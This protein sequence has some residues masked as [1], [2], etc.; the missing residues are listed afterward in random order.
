V[1]SESLA[2]GRDL[3][4]ARASREELAGRIARHLAVDG[5]VE[6]APGLY[7]YRESAPTG[8]RYGVSEPSFCVMAQG[9]KEVLLGKA[10]YRYDPVHYL[11]VSVGLPVV[12]HVVEA[13]PKRPYLAVRVV[14]DPA[15]VTEIL[16]EAGLLAARSPGAVR[17][18]AVSTLDASLLD[19]VLRLVRLVETPDD[20]A[21]LA[22]LAVREIVYRLALGEQSGRLRQIALVSG[23]AHRITEAIEF[24]RENFGKPLRIP[25]LARRLGMSVSGFHHHFKEVTAMSPLQFQKQLR[26]QEARRLL[27]AGD[28]DA[29][30]AG[31][32]VGYDDPSHFSREYKRHF[33]APPVRDIARLRGAA[34]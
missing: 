12:G 17:A 19:V 1:Q 5:N 11:L 2:E 6:A 34:G 4:R 7:L 8:P 28:A 25:G 30:T 23:R 29:A 18:L 26:L 3:E 16:F 10:R 20:Y 15:V 9:S 33:G 14:L 21:M 13:A 31:Y 24:L 22:P 27:L 32:R